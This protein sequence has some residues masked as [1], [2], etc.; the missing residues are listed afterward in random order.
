[1]DNDV[2]RIKCH[3]ASALEM[4]VCNEHCDQVE[5][6]NEAARSKAVELVEKFRPYAYAHESE[7]DYFKFETENAK[8]CALIS[9]DEILSEYAYCS[10]NIYDASHSEY[11]RKFWNQVKSEI[12]KL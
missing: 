10:T 8:Q 3:C 5:Y 9:V 12:E 6:T 4:K 11:R 1:M 7:R 2:K